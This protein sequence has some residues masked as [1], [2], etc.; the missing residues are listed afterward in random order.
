MSKIIHFSKYQGAGNDFVMLDNR[1]GEFNSLTSG[2]IAKICSRKYGIGADG[3]ILLEIEGNNIRKQDDTTDE[4]LKTRN[5]GLHLRMKYYNSD[6]SIASFC[7]NGG[8]C[9][10]LFAHNLQLSG[11]PLNSSNLF[12]AL[13]LKLGHVLQYAPSFLHSRA[14]TFE[15]LKAYPKKSKKARLITFT[16]DDGKHEALVY[17]ENRIQISMSN[18]ESVQ[19]C[20]SERHKVTL[21]NTGVPHAVVFTP[22]IE[23]APIQKDGREIRQDKDANV[24]FVQILPD[25]NIAIRTYERG[26]EDETDACGTGAVAAAIASVLIAPKQQTQKQ[27]DYLHDFGM[28]EV[29]VKTKTSTLKVY[30]T[31]TDNN[32]VREI[33]LE[34]G[35]TEVFKGIYK[36]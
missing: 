10:A 25:G 5:L 28:H 1:S 18:V 15:V 6:G 24:N 11:K 12:V 17:S 19:A 35:A 22:S 32:T 23:N 3:L 9:F 34:G 26:V 7:G 14:S 20:N 2:D 13:R 4:V 8:R 30:F 27:N 33:I 29:T 16:A 36:L 31:I 21:L